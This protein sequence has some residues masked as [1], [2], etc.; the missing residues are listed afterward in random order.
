MKT[1]EE[2]FYQEAAVIYLA[3]LEDPEIT[4][5]AVVSACIRYWLKGVSAEFIDVT[6]QDLAMADRII[7]E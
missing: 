6:V 4:D 2:Q 5:Y 3:D 1:L 7:I